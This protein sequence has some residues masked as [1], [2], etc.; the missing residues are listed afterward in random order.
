[1]VVCVMVNGG[2]CNACLILIRVIMTIMDFNR[3]TLHDFLDWISNAIKSRIAY[4]QKSTF[5]ASDSKLWSM[6]NIP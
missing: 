2:L 5:R 1:M 3:A 6:K 4:L